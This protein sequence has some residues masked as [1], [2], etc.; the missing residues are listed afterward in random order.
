MV[1]DPSAKGR[2]PKTIILV[3][4]KDWAVVLERRALNTIKRCQ[5]CSKAEGIC[6][7]TQL[8]S[9][10]RLSYDIL[11]SLLLERDYPRMSNYGFHK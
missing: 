6:F 8:C 11:K 2:V 7:V 5:I 4:P 10:E 3:D 1:K 9:I